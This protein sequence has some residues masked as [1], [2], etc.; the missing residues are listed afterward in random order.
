MEAYGSRKRMLLFLNVVAAMIPRKIWMYWE[1][2]EPHLEHHQGYNTLCVRA[3]RQLNPTWEVNLLNAT[4]AVQHIPEFKRWLHILSVQTRSDILRLS[5][6]ERYGGVWVDASVLPMRPLD[7][8]LGQHIANSGVFIFR[9]AHGERKDGILVSSW[10]IAS[11]RPDEPF[12]QIWLRTFVKNIEVTRESGRPLPYFIC[13]ISLTDAYRTDGMVREVVDRQTVS[14]R[15][16]HSSF[17]GSSLGCAN[18]NNHPV[19]YKRARGVNHTA[20]MQYLHCF[21]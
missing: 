12:I 16:P 14:Q 5:L 21:D 18:V 13:H 6:L 20:Y 1:H 9:Y 2:G 3:W 11:E 17:R 7:D 4:T 10:F 8:W 19:V 15:G